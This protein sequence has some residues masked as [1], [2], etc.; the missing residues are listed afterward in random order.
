MAEPPAG[1]S[2]GVRRGRPTCSR[3]LPPLGNP[4]VGV[5]ASRQSEVAAR[6]G[7]D[8]SGAA[9]ADHVV[10]AEEEGGQGGGEPGAASIDPARPHQRVLCRADVTM[11]TVWSP[12]PPAT[13]TGLL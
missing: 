1:G 9:Y 12:V 2:G 11:V 10:L 7:T 5:P 8:G 6:A 13:A 4:S 3:T